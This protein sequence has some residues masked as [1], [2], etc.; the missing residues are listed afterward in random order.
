MIKKNIATECCVTNGAPA[1]VY[2]WTSSVMPDG[3]EVLDTLFVELVDPP[4][5]IQ[6]SGLPVNVVPLPKSKHKITCKLPNDK[7]INI[8][9]QQ[10]DVLLNFAMTVHNCVDGSSACAMVPS[11]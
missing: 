3:R 1:T 8:I 10:V 4:R 9:R 2:D 5:T 6:L 7:P 11:L